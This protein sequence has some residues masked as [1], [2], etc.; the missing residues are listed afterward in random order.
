L[1]RHGASGQLLVPRKPALPVS[2][3]RSTPL[4][5][6]DAVAIGSENYRKGVF[7]PAESARWKFELGFNVEHFSLAVK[8][9]ERL[10]GLKEVL[11]DYL[12]E[13]RKRGL[14]VFVY[15]NVHWADVSQLKAHPDWFQ[16]D[17]SGKVI[18]DVYG[19]GLMPCV[20]SPGWREN[21]YSLME[22]VAELG[23]DG[24]FLDG[25]VFHVRGCY[26]RWCKGAFEER[27]RIEPPRKG[28]LADPRH[29]QLVGFQKESLASYMRG[30]YEVVK[31]VNP[32][33][34]VYMNGQ[35]PGPAWATGRDNEI[36]SRYQ[37]LVGAE[38][39]FE[40]YNLFE[41]P[42]FKPGLTAKLLE[43]QAPE[44]P[45]VVFIAANHRPW[46]R[47]VLTPAE[48]LNRCAQ[49]LANGAF[50]WIGI[51][52]WSGKLAEA[53][54]R[55]NSWVDAAGDLLVGTRDASSV[56]IYWS[57]STCD[58]YGG[59]VP[60]SDFTGETKRVARDYLK[61]VYGAYEMLLRLG[62]PFKLATSPRQLE[63]VEVLIVPN[64]AY[65]SDEETEGLGDFV[66]KGGVLVASFETGLYG[67][68]GLRGNFALADLFGADYVRSHYY[69]TY[70]NYMTA[71]GEWYPATAR[72]LEVKPVTAEALG[73][74]SVNTGGWYQPVELSSMP[75]LL[76]N[77]YGK[78]LV[79]YFTGN[80]FETYHAYRFSSYL[81]LLRRVLGERY[82]S[83][84]EL[85]GPSSYVEAELRAKGGK[86]LHLVNH[87]SA[88]SRPMLEL[89]PVHLRVRVKGEYRVESI[90]GRAAKVEARSGATELEL[91]LEDYALFA[92]EA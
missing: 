3:V 21:S 28:E 24:I 39:G 14:R 57:Q 19:R 6:I 30:A 52:W 77:A 58:Y 26:C 60:V 89:A 73:Y 16:V 70:E 4:K 17:Y 27:Y 82:R 61:S 5:I 68:E 44:K 63:G 33:V 51:T 38:G 87:T 79:F 66:E 91:T 48:L 56:A 86:L 23:P 36:L 41:T 12:R 78:G 75:S 47:E 65:L 20:N 31:R 42:V 88:L 64:A 46:C 45:R 40:Y 59:E 55:A 72:L 35:P 9:Y 67:P 71:W 92:L 25:P 76:R 32:E 11:E 80:F 81:D 34:A 49:A 29:P 54:R 69:G 1:I 13:T 7:D 2:W 62:I 43:A 8:A 85:E 37:D 83:P 90:V 10:R 53:V 50:Y 15:L 84:V 22:E 74:Y 18:D